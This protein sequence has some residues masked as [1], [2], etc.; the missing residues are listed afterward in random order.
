M[1]TTITIY[2]SEF[3]FRLVL[4]VRKSFGSSQLVN[5]KK[6]TETLQPVERRKF[7]K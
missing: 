6:K 5:S 2:F 1:Y 7:V 4:L 3:S